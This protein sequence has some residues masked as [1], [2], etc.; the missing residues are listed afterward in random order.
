MIGVELCEEGTGGLD[1][2]RG[3]RGRRL[4]GC[5]E[6]LGVLRVLLQEGGE[7][8]RIDDEDA[9]LADDTGHAGRIHG[10]LLVENLE[11]GVNQP[12]TDDGEGRCERRQ[13]AAEQLLTVAVDVVAKLLLGEV[14]QAL[15]PGIFTRELGLERLGLCVIPQLTLEPTPVHLEQAPS[16]AVHSNNNTLGH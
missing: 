14:H 12:A 5:A 13:L 6:L 16:E 8:G 10:L 3:V 7:L 1:V 2:Q 4:D 11:L 9:H 15:V